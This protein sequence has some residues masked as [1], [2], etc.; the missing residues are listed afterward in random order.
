[1][2]KLTKVL[3]FVAVALAI[4]ISVIV[5]ENIPLES[6]LK[7]KEEPLTLSMTE[8]GLPEDYIG[9][10]AADDI[11]RIEDAKT[12][13]DTWQTSYVTIEPTGIIPTGIGSRH[14]WVSAYTNSG[15]GGG[16]RRADV[17]KTAFDV[18]DEYGEYYIIQLPDGSYILSQMSKDDARK[19]KAG[20]E[21]TLPVGRKSAAHRQVLANIGD[22]CDEY[23]VNTNGVFYCINDKWCEE[24]SFSTE[25]LRIGMC[26]LMTIVIGVVFIMLIEKITKRTV[27]PKL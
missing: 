2:K 7:G 1:M 18:F 19:L 22:L 24:H 10:P 13:E 9:K 6:M 11:P 5:V 4:V 27:E 23:N 21:I 17:T 26:A 8:G 15:R 20:Q 14:P 16:R 12:W 25:M 3:E